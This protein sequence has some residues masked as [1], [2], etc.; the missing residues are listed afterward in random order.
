[1]IRPP[2]RAA[3]LA[4]LLAAACNVRSPA[5]QLYSLAY[6][7][8]AAGNY[9]SASDTFKRVMKESAQSPQ[10]GG[11]A[12]LHIALVGGMAR[13][14]KDIA[15]SYRAG[16]KQAG[17]APHARRMRTM[18]VDYFGRARGRSL[19]MVEA[20]DLFFNQPAAG[21]LRV[22]FPAFGGT[23]AT[24]S[25]GKIRQG[26]WLEDKELVAAEKQSVRQGA[27]A[28]LAHL[29]PGNRPDLSPAHLS[30][31]LAEELLEMSSL[32]DKDALDD[33]RLLR[34]YH[35]RAETLAER[36][37]KLGLPGDAAT[38]GRLAEV[39]QRCQK[40]LEKK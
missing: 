13:S 35:Q 22:D 32:Y 16:A 39:K 8:L 15:E 18:P 7:Q 14:Y 34:L 10:A 12:V 23:G 25:L 28:L 40:A 33:H 24:M 3:A 27:E 1:M 11:A 26:Q 36:A 38:A 31:A 4:A 21:P 37:E 6:E 17:A 2:M 19:E 9:Y 30:L 5:E 20:I 29:A